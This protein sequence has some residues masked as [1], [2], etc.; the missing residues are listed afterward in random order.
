MLENNTY[1]VKLLELSHSLFSSFS[2][3]LLFFFSFSLALSGTYLSSHILF[4]SFYISSLYL[5]LCLTLALSHSPFSLSLLLSLDVSLS[6]SCSSILTLSFHS[7][8]QSLSLSL[9]LHI[10]LNICISCSHSLVPLPVSYSLS[11]SF[12]YFPIA[13]LPAIP[14][15]CCL[16]LLSLP[17][18]SHTIFLSSAR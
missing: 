15:C 18:L 1:N 6:L 3:F 17:S 7:L 16:F 8:S 11:L 12:I 13:N 4:W 5:L 2:R 14:Y 9:S 10:A